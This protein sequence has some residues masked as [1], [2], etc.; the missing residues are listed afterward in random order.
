MFEN[1][2]FEKWLDEKSQELVNKIGSGE[3]LSSEE[4]IILVLKAQSNHFYHL[5]KDLRDEMKE[6]REDTTKQI[7]ELRE[8]MDRKFEQVDKRFEQVDRRFEQVE[9]RFKQ[10]DKRFEQVDK[11]FEQVDKR[12]DAIIARM[13]RFMI[14]SLGLTVSSTLFILG[15]MYKL[16]G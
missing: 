15:M 5:D 16:I 2:I 14:W 6:L 11:R 10:V 8:D 3:A 1:N 4:M 7:S 9:E 12:F 13:D